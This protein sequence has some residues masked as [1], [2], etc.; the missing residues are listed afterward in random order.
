[1]FNFLRYDQLRSF[2]FFIDILGE[3]HILG[4]MRR[5]PVVIAHQEVAPVGIVLRTDTRDQGFRR[6]AFGFCAQHDRRTVGICR[7][8]KVH[9]V[10]LHA[11]KSRPNVAVEL[12][13]DV[14]DMERAVSIGKCGGDEYFSGHQKLLGYGKRK[15]D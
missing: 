1:M 7:A 13:D 15:L 6:D 8:H 4:R 5:M 11:L 3:R 14:P 2:Q 12:I 10:A 9:F